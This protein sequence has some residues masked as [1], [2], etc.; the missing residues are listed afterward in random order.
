LR[1]TAKPSTVSY[2]MA[3][4]VAMETG[5]VR[6]GIH[7][8]LRDALSIEPPTPDTDLIESGLLDSLAIITLIFEL[9]QR[10]AISLPL[11]R[12][13]L[14]DLRTITA[15]GDLVARQGISGGTPTSG[16]LQLLRTGSDPVPVFLLPGAWGLALG[17]LPLARSLSTDRPVYGLQTWGSAAG[18]QP[19][20]TVPEI[21]ARSLAAI[22]DVEPDGPFTLIGY[23][24]GGQ[25]AYE[26]ACLLRARGKSVRVLALIDT[27]VS[28]A[29]LPP[30]ACLR[31]VLL[32]PFR[33]ARYIL[34]RPR[35]RVA[36][37]L[38]KVARLVRGRRAGVVE[39]IPAPDAPEL[40]PF[41]RA[42]AAAAR[43]YRPGRYPGGAAL[44]V[45][46]TTHP[47]VC[48]AHAVWRDRVQGTLTVMQTPGEHG[49]IISVSTESV[50]R[51]VDR[52]L[53][54][55]HGQAA[56]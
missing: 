51:S 10:F 41:M 34:A 18:A 45:S 21:A 29:A 27:R 5:G 1:N 17:M 47:L 22:L 42:I 7:E 3:M 40:D 16:D 2:E 6:E 13:E 25:V 33:Y 44:L 49:R 53:A 55:T 38:R 24:F 19:P 30:V 20:Y 4:S 52:L 39:L 50:A 56:G 37:S 12:V 9:E 23:S 48:S 8:I 32:Q 54:D 28:P 35:A 36:Q 15:L 14:T 26:L 43:S 11:E 46:D 31:L